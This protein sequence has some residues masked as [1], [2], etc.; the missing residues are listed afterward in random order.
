VQAAAQLHNLR[1]EFA[2]GSPNLTEVGGCHRERRVV[3]GPVSPPFRGRNPD[4]SPWEL[5]VLEEQ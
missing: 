4:S 2:D 3:A 5:S 1:K